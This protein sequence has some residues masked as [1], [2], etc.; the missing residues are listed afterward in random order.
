[1]LIYLDASALLRFLRRATTGVVPLSDA[2]VVV[3]S[4]LL[5]VELRRAL[6]RAWLAKKIN[7]GELEAKLNEAVA[8]VETFHLFPVGDEVITF[9]RPRVPFELGV[10]GSIHVATAQLVQKDAGRPMQFWTHVDAVGAAAALRGLDVR[11][12]SAPGHH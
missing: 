10:M 9:A 3:S 7:S 2:D 4:D 11:G 6:E 8:L 1:M 5:E 12:S